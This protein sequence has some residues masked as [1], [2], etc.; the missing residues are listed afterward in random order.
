MKDN[1]MSAKK[2]V[3]LSLFALLFAISAYFIYLKLNPK[4]LP[5]NLIVGTG[6]IDGDLVNL[7]TKYPGRVEKIAVEEGMKINK[8]DIVAI[9]GSK[10]KEAK[11]EEILCKIE[12]ASKEREARTTELEIAKR[13]LPLAVEKA[14]LVL[15]T[16]MH[17]FEE[18]QKNTQSLEAVVEQD[19]KDY[20]RLKNLFEQKLVE[21]RKVELAKLKL[22]TDS[23][24]LDAAKEKL[25]QTADAV[26]ISENDLKNAQSMLLKIDVL[27]KTVE[28]LGKNI[29]ALKAV[30]KEIDSIISE[31]TI[32][33]PV[34]G[35]VTRKIANAGEVVGAGMS[36][37]T[38]VSPEN[39]YLKIFVDTLQN[40][41]IKIG[42]KAVIFLDSHPHMPISAKVARVA[43][44]AE[45]TPK[46]VSVRSDRIQR[47][48]AVHLKP[49]KPNQLL[50][51]GLPAVGIIS[52][53][54]KNLPE[55]LDEIPP[56]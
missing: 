32:R 19:R 14:K 5:P 18:I 8:A 47:V 35:Y 9:L 45:F 3:S 11:R 41:K 55:S 56:I 38:I 30:K 22:V 13:T 48:F 15:K 21:K 44:K 28:A 46:E 49:V 10:E 24:K 26:K 20:L 4:S 2:Y 36:I 27:Q 12:A 54:G 23:K 52:I 31:M 25:K 1:A 50:K 29:D 6:R 51:L 7:N 17:Q 16:R 37:A 43:Q 40:G 42:D 39:L 33:S 34:D 53:D